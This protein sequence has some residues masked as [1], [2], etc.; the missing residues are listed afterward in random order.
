MILL[1]TDKERTI[2]TRVIRGVKH[3][4][5]PPTM[6]KMGY[7]TAPDV[8]TRFT[9]NHLKKHKFINIAP[10]VDFLLKPEWSG[11]FRKGLVDYYEEQWKEEFPKNVWTT[12]AYTGCSEYRYMPEEQVKAFVKG[13]HNKYP[14]YNHPKKEGY[15]HL[16]FI[17]FDRKKKTEY[18]D[19]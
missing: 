5:D 14:Y 16:Y 12:K 6:V 17:R 8:L 2:K 15:L 4:I 7:T 13:L 19:E 11:W 18:D 9:E 10:V 3:F 1:E